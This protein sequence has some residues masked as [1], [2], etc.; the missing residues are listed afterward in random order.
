MKKARLFPVLILI[1]VLTVSAVFAETAEKQTELYIDQNGYGEIHSANPFV[2]SNPDLDISIDSLGMAT[3]SGGTLLAPCSIM[4]LESYPV[5]FRIDPESIRI[6]EQPAA[7][8][9]ISTYPE[10]CVCESYDFGMLTI[11][12]NFTACGV[13]DDQIKSVSMSYTLENADT[14]ET[15]DEV[16]VRLETVEIDLSFEPHES[17]AV[18]EAH[19]RPGEKLEGDQ[20]ILIWDDQGVRIWISEI[21]PADS[22]ADN[23]SMKIELVCENS[24]SVPVALTITG[25]GSP[26]TRSCVSYFNG[27]SGA[28]Y[29]YLFSA[30]SEVGFTGYSTTQGDVTVLSRNS[31]TGDTTQK[32]P[33]AEDLQSYTFAWTLTS[34]CTKEFP[35][36]VGPEITLFFDHE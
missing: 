26:G 8:A 32:I 22:E 4:N 6:N 27:E 25:H 33:A 19:I 20:R 2:Y 17:E 1:L 35:R 24:I 12:V 36:I 34:Y 16:K 5:R 29:D 7:G 14:Q 30:E 21:T 31:M 3:Y 28:F 10:E 11:V 15:I 9:V 18:T 23:S 13:P